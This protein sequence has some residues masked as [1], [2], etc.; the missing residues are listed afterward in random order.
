VSE[1]S[2]ASAWSA[3]PSIGSVWALGSV[4]AADEARLIVLEHLPQAA[5][6]TLTDRSR[7]AV[8]SGGDGSIVV[9]V[10][11]QAGRLPM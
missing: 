7:R 3:E 8:L 1:A 6:M 4:F 5:P 10:D 2:A 9:V 11:E